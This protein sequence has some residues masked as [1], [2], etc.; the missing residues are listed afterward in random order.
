MINEHRFSEYSQTFSRLK[1]KSDETTNSFI[2]QIKGKF[3]TLGVGVDRGLYAVS[4]EAP[5]KEIELKNTELIQVKRVDLNSDKMALLFTLNDENMLSIFISFVID[6]ESVVADD[7]E[8]SI[9]EMYNRYV[10]WQ[11]MFK[12]ESKSI[13][14]GQVKGL[15]GELNILEKYM[16]PKYGVDEA[17]IGWLGTDGSHKDFTY[18]DGN[19]YEAKAV[20][21]GKLSVKIS[22]IEQLQADTPGYLIITELEKTSNGN[23]NGVRLY[24]LLNRVKDL[25]QIESIELEFLNKISSIGLS[26]DVFT[27]ISHEGNQFGYVI[28]NV[29]CYLV[30]ESF[31]RIKRDSLSES[32][33]LVNYELIIAK[34][35]E[36]K[37][38]FE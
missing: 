21:V 26:L 25:I 14:E 29:D 2:P 31:P 19:W 12:I 16:I 38:E 9:I 34:I 13:S 28:H 32:I 15:I 11:K 30:D 35:Q 7:N 20:N 10:F 27:D 18:N 6:L 3:V 17:I 37:V 8:V 5:I 1:N 4:I 23:P 22:S 36:T 33:G 24:E